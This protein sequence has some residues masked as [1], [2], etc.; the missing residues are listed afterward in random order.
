MI[1]NKD[2]FNDKLCEL[3][4]EVENCNPEFST[5]GMIFSDKAKEYIY[6]LADYSRGLK[7]YRRTMEGE[8][9]IARKEYEEVGA[10]ASRMYIDMLHKIVNAP[11]EIHME[12]VPVMLMPL[13]DERL[14]GENNV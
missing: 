3:M 8:T 11:T 14:R 7:S 10:S 9:G 1:K 12:L 13:I 4:E 2:E 6:E 5:D